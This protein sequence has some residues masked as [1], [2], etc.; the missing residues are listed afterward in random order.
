MIARFALS[1]RRLSARGG[2]TGSSA[3]AAYPLARKGDPPGSL[4]E[5]GADEADDGALIRE[6]ADDIGTPR[7]RSCRKFC[8]LTVR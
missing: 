1:W 8:R 4:E 6:Y 3:T 2:K 7:H 5:D